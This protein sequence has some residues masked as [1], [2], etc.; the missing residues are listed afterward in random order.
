MGCSFNLFTIHVINKW[1]WS[2]CNKGDILTFETRNIHFLI[3]RTI[4]YLI[5]F[6]HYNLQLAP[7]G[8]HKPLGWVRFRCQNNTYTHT[9]KQNKNRSKYFRRIIL[10]IMGNKTKNSCRAS[11]LPSGLCM[12][13]LNYT[14]LVL[15]LK[16]R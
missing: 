11:C 3:G 13:K 10:L 4:Y 6:H 1:G 9:H 12:Y 7:C 16:N 2:C 8:P 15:A 14:R 5:T